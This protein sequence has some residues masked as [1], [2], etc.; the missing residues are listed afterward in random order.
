MISLLASKC[1]VPDATR[2]EDMN[3][4]INLN[5]RP[6]AMTL[7][8]ERTAVLVVDMQNDF[9]S[10]GGMM[11]RAGVDISRIQKAVGPISKILR[12][13]RSAGMRIVY[14]KMG[15][16]PDLSDLGL[17]DSVNRQRHS[18]FGVGQECT[19]PDGSKG[20]F[21]VH[22]TW[23]TEII[24]ELAPQ[25]GDILICKSRYSGFYR[26][27]L[28]EILKKLSVR[29]LIVTG[30]T[31]SICVESTIRDAMFRDYR[32]ALVSDAAAEPI[33][34]ELPRSNH[35]ASLLVV[36]TLLGWVVDSKEVC[37]ALEPHVLSVASADR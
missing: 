2:G 18:L 24:P 33:G 31:T 5:A 28:D 25:T 27:E 8:L 17:E 22:G 16:Q 23:N 11:D 21:L 37:T 10:K 19:A 35:E 1:L 36:E 7:N 15:Y 13:A 26:T 14:L 3:R 29:N 34:Q 12:L 9:A 30:C 32:C 4:T 6:Q 20:R